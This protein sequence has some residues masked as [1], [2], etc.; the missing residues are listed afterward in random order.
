ME[1]FYLADEM[2]KQRGQ[3][4]TIKVGEIIPFQSL[5]SSKSESQW[6]ED[7]KKIVYDLGSS[8]A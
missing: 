6:A 8:N 3:K 7:I 1:L 2:Y 4:V 5:D